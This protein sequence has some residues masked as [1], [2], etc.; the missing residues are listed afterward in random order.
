MEW[1]LKLIDSVEGFARFNP[2][3]KLPPEKSWEQ[4]QLTFNFL[5]RR[6][7]EQLDV[8][9]QYQLWSYITTGMG[10]LYNI[11]SLTEQMKSDPTNNLPSILGFT[12]ISEPDFYKNCYGLM[13]YL[14]KLYGETSMWRIT[15]L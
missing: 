7:M 6:E 14:K 5:S 10:G 13:Q 1:R 3:I 8:N 12:Q 15:E 4:Y 2:I 11:I 9:S